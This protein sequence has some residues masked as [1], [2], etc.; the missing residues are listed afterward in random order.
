M[1]LFLLIGWRINEKDWERR[2]AGV[3]WW[4]REKNLPPLHRQPGYWVSTWLLSEYLVLG[5]VPLYRVNIWLLGTHLVI[6]WVPAYWIS[7]SVRGMNEIWWCS[8]VTVGLV[9]DSNTL[10]KMGKFKLQILNQ[11]STG[12]LKIVE[13]ILQRVFLAFGGFHQAF[14]T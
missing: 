1:C 10:H 9:L 2:G 8:T 5:W 4:P 11:K 7:N 3:L 13:N 6:G 14:I 12:N